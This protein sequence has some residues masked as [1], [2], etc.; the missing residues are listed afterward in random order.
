[1]THAFFYEINYSRILRIFLSTSR[2][3]RIQNTQILSFSWAGEGENEQ[4]YSLGWATEVI[5]TKMYEND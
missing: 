5:S 4:K 3:F 1:M 2:F